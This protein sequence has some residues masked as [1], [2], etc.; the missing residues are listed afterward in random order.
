M[1]V[2]NEKEQEG[3]K[4]DEDVKFE[5]NKEAA[6][7][8]LTESGSDE[9]K[10]SYE[11]AA[12]PAKEDTMGTSDFPPLSEMDKKPKLEDNVDKTSEIIQ[13]GTSTDQ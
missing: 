9:P 7:V 13:Q 11:E 1:Q 2:D 12:I 10:I 5:V 8:P 6:I 3:V 4:H